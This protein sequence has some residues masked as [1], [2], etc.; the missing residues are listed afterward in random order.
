MDPLTGLTLSS[1]GFMEINKGL[2]EYARKEVESRICFELEGGYHTY[3]LGEVFAGTM[4][5][6]AGL[7]HDKM[8][9]TETK[10]INGSPALVSEIKDT[11]GSYWKV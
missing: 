5:L 4:A 10:D 11:M 6:A 2:L 8:R 9:Y 1:Q 7:D 3:A